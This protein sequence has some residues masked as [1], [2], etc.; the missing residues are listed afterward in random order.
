[1][2]KIEYLELLSI[3]AINIGVMSSGG[4]KDPEYSRSDTIATRSVL[5]H[6]ERE[7]ISRM[8]GDHDF[9]IEAYLFLTSIERPFGAP[10][11]FSGMTY[12]LRSCSSSTPPVVARRESGNGVVVCD[13]EPQKYDSSGPIEFSDEDEVA[14]DWEFYHIGLP[15]I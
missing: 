9:R 14:H 13:N 4:F 15:M 2:T 3:A 8:P 6:E 12:Y 7:R 5:I 1:M 11:T 10:T